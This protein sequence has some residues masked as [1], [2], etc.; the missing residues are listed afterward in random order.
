MNNNRIFM[1]AGLAAVTVLLVVATFRYG[2]SSKESSDHQGHLEHTENGN[3]AG[4]H[5]TGE[6]EGKIAKTLEQIASGKCEHNVLIYQCATCR[7]E[8]GVVRVPSSLWKN[9]AKKNEGL[10]STFKVTK[11]EVIPGLKVTGKVQLNENTAVHISPRIP[12]IIDSVHVD[13]GMRVNK[14]SI[15]FKINSTE[16]GKA[17]S[18]Y[19]R[20]SALTVLS[21]KNLEREK[22]L[23]ERKITSEQDMIE[24]EMAFEQ[25]RTEL[26]AA[27]QALHVVGLSE[28]D[29][30]ALKKGYSAGVG[31]LSV[32]APIAGTIIEKHAVVGELVEPGKDVM[33][34]ADLSNMWVWADIYEHDLSKLLQAEKDGPIPVKVYVRAFP[35]RP[36]RGKIDYIGATMTERTRT[37]KV[38]ATIENPGFVLRQGMFCEINIGIGN[39]E[40]VLA[41]P[42]A[43]LLSDEGN[44]FIFTH[45][46]E[47][48]Y[49]RRSVKRGLKDGETIIAE[50]AFLLKSDVLREKMGAGCAD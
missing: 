31:R 47:D 10:L 21:K 42:R 34:L 44:D 29:I 13:L 14:E 2:Q 48:Y 15:L 4:H 19:E 37:V 12:G 36:F 5:H 27:E 1:L 32:N 26:I 40:E 28:E 11:R 18:D 3:H 46:K 49:A 24:A 50:G 17:F 22:S 7:Y 39:G 30:T 20:S 33:L 35:G 25:H 9:T 38:R 43:A 41:V 8:V 45:W 6:D 16:L 23:F